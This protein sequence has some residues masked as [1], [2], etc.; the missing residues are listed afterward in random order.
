MREQRIDERVLGL[1]W[2]RLD[3]DFDITQRAGEELREIGSLALPGLLR[4]VRGR[5]WKRG[6]APNW[7]AVSWL[8]Q[9]GAEA[10][11]GVI[12]ALMA[13]DDCDARWA[14]G[15]V[16]GYI[17]APAVPAL[18]ETLANED[19]DIRLIV[20][21][22]LTACADRRS[23]PALIEALG[24]PNPD[25]SLSATKAIRYVGDVSAVADLREA[26]ASGRC[27]SQNAV[28]WAISKLEGG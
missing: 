3:L 16:L 26:L 5:A 25:V 15:E 18:I 10:V 4:V 19:D 9:I 24:D 12:H 14:A 22:A 21:Y 28:R 11:P 13:C 23:L 7:E 20:L 27:A 17:G 1:I 2:S 6:F 8:A